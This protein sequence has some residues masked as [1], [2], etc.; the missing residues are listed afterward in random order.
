MV[1][2]AISMIFWGLAGRSRLVE[3]VVLGPLRPQDLAQSVLLGGA[4]ANDIA[5]MG[6]D[7][8]DEGVIDLLVDNSAVLEE[9][10]EL[11]SKFLERQIL[12]AASAR[13]A[14]SAMK[15]VTLPTPTPM[16]GVPRSKRS[17]PGRCRRWRR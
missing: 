10:L 3:L 4:V 9:Q 7:L 2:P 14:S 8:L 1:T 13:S 11:K 6:L 15:V 16:A 5:V 12:S 17:G